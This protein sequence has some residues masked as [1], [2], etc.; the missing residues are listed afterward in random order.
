MLYSYRYIT[1]STFTT[2]VEWHFFKLRALPCDN[3][4]QH[5][6]DSHLSVT[7][8][9][10]L[11]RSV[12]GQGNALQWGSYCVPHT[13]FRFVSEGQVEQTKPYCLH[14]APAPYYATPTHLTSCSEAMMRVAK[15]CES[16]S[17]IMQFVHRHIAYSPCSTSVS[18]TAVEVFE[19]PLGVCQDYA[20]LMLALCRAKGW[21][22]R[23]VNGFIGGEGETH[24]WVEVSDG[25]VWHPFDPTHNV[26]PQW[27]YVKIAHG[28]DA[29][30]CPT[31][32]GRFYGWTSETMSISVSVECKE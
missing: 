18:T 9:C 32:R 31:N 27:G 14:E 17:D 12:D 15:Q 6:I 23:Y 2:E 25:E 5:V 24:A 21:C 19:N 30:D 3:E 22:A 26:C 1:E 10:Q 8:P 29:D 20:H 7:P 13:L 11:H 28:R 4:F 16:V